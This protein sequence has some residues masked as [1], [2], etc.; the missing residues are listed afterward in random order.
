MNILFFGWYKIF[1]ILSDTKE[2]KLK[3]MLNYTEYNL[4]VMQDS[5]YIY[6]LKIL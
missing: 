5:E 3:I 6:I 2:K 4:F 1:I